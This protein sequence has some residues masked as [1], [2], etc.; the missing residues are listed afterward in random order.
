M[1][2]TK[3]LALPLTLGTLVLATL[4]IVV[5]VET[6]EERQ[7]ASA[8]RTATDRQ[9]SF[10]WTGE[11]I[12]EEPAAAV[13]SPLRLTASDGTGLRLVELTAR[14]VLEPP[15]AFTELRMSFENPED[16]VREGRFRITLPAGAAISRF[17]MKIGGHWQ[18]GEVVERQRARQVYEDFLHRRQDPALLEHEAG[19]EFSA[20]VFP[21]PARAVKEL[22]VSYS[23]ELPGTG[24]AYV[25]PLLGLPEIDRLDVQ[26][27]LADKPADGQPASS[28]GG[29]VRER[30]VISLVKQGWTPN[31]DFEVLQSEVGARRGLRHD[32]L[33]V[34]RVAAPVD[35]ELQEIDSLYVLVDSSVS[36]ALGFE[37]QIA[38]L[39]Q[40]LAGLRDGAGPRTPV[41]VAAFDQA[42]HPVFAGTAGEIGADG[43]GDDTWGRLRGLGALGASDPER[44][45]RWLGEELSGGA[46]YRRV[47]LVSDGVATAGEVE[48]RALRAAVRDLG[49][50]GVERLDVLAVGG[51]RD[52]ELLRHLVTGNLE[53]DGQVIDAD[54]GRGEIARRLTHASRSGIEVAVPGA[55]WVWPRTLDAVQPG[56]EVLVY[57]DLPVGR[58]LSVELAGAAVGVGVAAVLDAEPALLQRAWVQARIDRLLRLRETDFADDADVRQALQRE[59]TGLSVEHRVLSP[60]TAFLVLETE[61]DYQRYGLDRRARADILTVGAAGLEVLARSSSP[62]A[63]TARSAAPKQDA[64]VD[65]TLGAAEQSFE[66]EPEGPLSLAVD[67]L[68]MDLE[69]LG[70]VPQGN[71]QIEAVSE[72]RRELEEEIEALAREMSAPASPAA[73]EPSPRTQRIPI[74]DPAPDEAEPPPARQQPVRQQPVPDEPD[75]R[76]PASKEP[77]TPALAGRLAEVIE[78]VDAGRT[79]Q[80]LA[81]ASEWLAESPGDVLALVALGE[82][83]EAGGDLDRAARAYG[84]LI[85]LF[86]SRAD[87]RRYAGERLERLAG[88]TALELAVDTYRKALA[89]RPDHPSSHRLLAYA[90]LRAGRPQEAFETLAAAVEQRY[91]GDRFRGVDH[92]LRDDLGLA[93]AAWKRAEPQRDGEIRERLRRAGGTV[94]DQPSLRFVLTWETDANDVDLHVWDGKGGHAYYS[95]KRLRSGGELYADV[96]TGYGPECFI[97]R[98]PAHRRAYPYRLQAHYYNRG[99]MGY[100]MGLLRIVEHDGDGVLSFDQRPFVVMNDRAFVELGKVEKG[101]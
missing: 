34:V 71:A 44:A 23:H 21:I 24:D 83:L 91:P 60:F 28:L 75:R 89:Q 68:A 15:L 69:S 41:A 43:T 4:A 10:R 5:T 36:R 25:I 61:W 32:N 66:V 3:R 33:A 95:E 73:A 2:H 47:L 70:Y 38:L 80:A 97:I 57:A 49:D 79:R 85:D 29:S 86:P 39:R 87:L 58:P 96:T 18:E 59:A 6:E 65:A 82:A 72:R 64:F 81:L 16:R 78:L 98:E 52:E 92:I 11:P 12:G 17:A 94:E 56:D 42:V 48:G 90:L 9:S 93:A 100:G 8:G 77:G 19:N 50:L 27:Q 31:A 14:G 74:P 1:T 88:E 20:R 40:L 99:P 101:K 67:D 35:S 7:Q 54:A 30:R 63:T 37:G 22:V 84:S 46:V 55:A 26:V 76:E 62:P 53:D 45:L 13:E 51:Q